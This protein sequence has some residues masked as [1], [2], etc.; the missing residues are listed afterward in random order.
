MT[1]CFI[2]AKKN[3]FVIC[4]R[5]GYYLTMVNKYIRVSIFKRPVLVCIPIYFLCGNC[6]ALLYCEILLILLFDLSL[7]NHIL[8]NDYHKSTCDLTYEIQTNNR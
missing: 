5:F 2:E 7:G 8:N 1:N 3:V 6:T 4:V